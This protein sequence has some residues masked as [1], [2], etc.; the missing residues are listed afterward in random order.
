MGVLKFDIPRGSGRGSIN[1]LSL[2]SA[3]AS[4]TYLRTP[5]SLYFTLCVKQYIDQK[6]EILETNSR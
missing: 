1:N 6:N 5:Q 4:T 3:F 2:S